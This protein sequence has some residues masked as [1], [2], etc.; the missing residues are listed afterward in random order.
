VTARSAVTEGVRLD[1]AAAYGAA[2]AGLPGMTPARLRRVLDGFQPV[3]AWRALAAGA[4][5]ADRIRRFEGGA[6]STDIGAVAEA[7]GRAGISVLLRDRPGY[8]ARLVGDRGQPAVLFAAGDPLGADARPSAAI[9]GTRSATHYGRSV[10]AE[11]GGA[12]AEAGVVVV[13]GLAS[14]IDGAAH[15]GVLRRSAGTGVPIAVVGTGLDVVYPPAHASLWRDVAACGA[16][17]SEAPLG[18]PPRPR[19]FPARNRIIAAL[20]DVVVV[21][22]CHHRGGALYTA[23]AAARRGIPVGAVPGSVRSPAS[24]GCN[25]LLADGCVPIRDADD[26]LTAIGLARAEPSGARLPT[27]GPERGGTA[28]SG[29][30]APRTLTSS[31]GPHLADDERRQVYEAVDGHPTGL[32]S[33]VLRTGLPFATIAVACDALVEEGSL[34]AGPGWWSRR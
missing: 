24:V 1:E 23:E 6:R 34:A 33:I 8:P 20:A 26:V 5:P 2:L 27:G 18:T 31:S 29:G 16:V 22:E 7:Y 14:G 13:S 11:L 4:H 25:A 17:L 9:V 30:R 3:V 15:A 12:L 19:V 10:A 21:V 32:E 28:R